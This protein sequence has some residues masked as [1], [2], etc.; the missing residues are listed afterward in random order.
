MSIITNLLFKAIKSALHYEKYSTG[1]WLI[2]VYIKA[3]ALKTGG[4]HTFGAVKR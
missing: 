4:K 1:T 3:C 2:K